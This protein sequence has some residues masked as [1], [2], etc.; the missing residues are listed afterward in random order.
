MQKITITIFI[1]LISLSSLYA[2]PHDKRDKLKAYKTAYITQ[3]LDLT[4]SEA[5]KFWPIYN[6]YE[7]EIFQSKVVRMK[8]A[9]KKIRE[10]GGFEALT[11]RDAEQLLL[12]LTKNEQA[13]VDAKKALFRDLKNVISSKKILKL[14]QAEHQFNRKLL[15]DYRK[16]NM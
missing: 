7:K 13:L 2:Q 16:K 12:K 6:A 10:K 8:E 15:S 5:E 9:R 4:S 1:I 3:Q 11:E 14:N